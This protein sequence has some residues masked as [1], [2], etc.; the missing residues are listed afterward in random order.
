MN[1]NLD[2]T[3]TGCPCCLLELEE[4]FEEVEGQ[5]KRIPLES[6]FSHPAEAG[7]RMYIKVNV[8]H[9][10]RV[11][12]EFLGSPV[13]GELLRLAGRV[14]DVPF[15]FQ[16]AL[17]R[18]GLKSSSIEIRDATIEAAENWGEPKLA[19]ILYGYVDTEEWLTRYARGVAKDLRNR[20]DGGGDAS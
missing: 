7:L 5:L 20:G 17:V 13:A 12:R 9:S 15:H 8:F 10:D 16:S 11:I 6:G 3:N 2:K 19:K 1:K 14:E 4:L 18:T